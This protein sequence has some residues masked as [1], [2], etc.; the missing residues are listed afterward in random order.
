MKN[1]IR[2]S[3]DLLLFLFIFIVLIIGFKDKIK[4][5]II[6]YQLNNTKYSTNNLLNISLTSNYKY[7]KEKIK[8]TLKDLPSVYIFNTHYE[9]EYNDTNVIEMSKILANKLKQNNINSIF[10]DTDYKEYVKTNNLIGVNNYIMIRNIIEHKI[11]D[12]MSLV[13]DLHRDS[14]T[15][16][17]SVVNINGIKYAKVLFVV[18]NYYSD[19]L[20]KYDLANKLN[21]YLNKKYKGISRGVY[22]KN[23]KGF[24]QDLSENMILL[25]LGGY[26]NDK[27]ELMNT[28]DVIV[29]MIKEIIYGR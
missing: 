11:N 6:N 15:K 17:D 5:N 23:G 7:N 14:I 26:Q 4:E 29:E 12:K 19:Y 16:K 3:S 2:R 28:I 1:I 8:E 10:E 20:K 13:I 18:D 9:E 21:S 25:E 27:E 24:N 22:V